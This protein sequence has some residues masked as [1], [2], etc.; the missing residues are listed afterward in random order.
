MVVN[1][2]LQGGVAKPCKGNTKPVHVTGKKAADANKVPA[3]ETVG[4]GPGHLCKLAIP[5]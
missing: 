2:Q 3:L 1:A 4:Y 5:N